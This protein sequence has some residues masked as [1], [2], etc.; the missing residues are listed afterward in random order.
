MLV[1]GGYNNEACFDDL[2]IADL[3]DK[4]RPMKSWRVLQFEVKP[5]ARTSHA[6]AVD[7]Q[8]G[9]MYLF[10]GSGAAFGNQNMKYFALSDLWAFDLYSQTW[11]CVDVRGSAPLPRYGHSCNLYHGELVVIGGTS[12]RD[13]FSDV[14]RLNLTSKTWKLAKT[15]GA[16]PSPRYRH[17]S[18]QSGDCIY[19]IGGGDMVTSYSDLFSLSLSSWRWTL[20]EISEDY[21]D[22]FVHPLSRHSAVM[23]QDNIFI[24]GGSD[25]RNP[26]QKMKSMMKLSISKQNLCVIHQHGDQPREREFHTTVVCNGC[27]VLFGGVTGERTRLNDMNAFRL[28]HSVLVSKIS[29]DKLYLELESP[30]LAF[31]V[32]L[33]CRDPKTFYCHSAV[34]RARL[35]LFEASLLTS[36]SALE[37]RGSVIKAVLC[38][39]YCDELPLISISEALD[40]LS[41]ASQYCVPPLMSL[42]T[43]CLS[44]RLNIENCTATASFLYDNMTDGI[45]HKSQLQANIQAYAAL[46]GEDGLNFSLKK[47]SVIDLYRTVINYLKHF[48]ASLEARGL[49]AALSL[50]VQQLVRNT[51]KL[52]VK[53]LQQPI[54][55][56]ED[57]LQSLRADERSFDFNILAEGQPIR[58]H[59]FMLAS[60]AEF[61]SSLLS[62]PMAE[63]STFEVSVE[64]AYPLMS[65]LV[66]YIYQGF[67]CLEGLSSEDLLV[68]VQVGDYY[69]LKNSHLKDEV[70]RRLA[71]SLTLDN[72][73]EY[74][75]VACTMCMDV[76]KNYA[77]EFAS[78]HLSSLLERPEVYK[79]TPEVYVELLKWQAIS[80]L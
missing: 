73:F 7:Q 9:V 23:L 29:T 54:S 47:V 6:C 71:E 21:T 67:K 17:A 39:A 27:I 37:W 70:G 35:P 59:K 28:E 68:L 63:T 79:L 3:V 16:G 50:P 43:Y 15:S 60:G 4:V 30:T 31:D 25:S 5:A 11:S 55:S 38:Y 74:L 34:L 45:L 24:F 77:C 2:A 40:L 72:I 33:M 13:F 65:L 78:R 12:G 19:I 75:E 46:R 56:V 42:T 76:L 26:T 22:H 51:T 41:F 10:G 53:P 48:S 62:T 61:F 58:A 52:K 18:V 36:E 1:S 8:A 80:K 32:R 66:D 64:H 14:H 49:L 57:D 20:L 69:K 44:T